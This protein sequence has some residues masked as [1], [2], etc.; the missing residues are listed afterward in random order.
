MKKLND[1]LL[2]FY[3]KIQDVFCSEKGQTLV[4]HSVLVGIS[5]AISGAIATFRDN[6]LIILVLILLLLILLLFWKPKF[7][8][9]IV[10]I[11]V[12]LAVLLFVYRWVELGHI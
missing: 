9:A 4:E 10:I 1:L 3:K 6:P 11:A 8:A 5:G 7:V 12:L 2:S